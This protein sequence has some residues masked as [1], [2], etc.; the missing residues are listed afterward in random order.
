MQTIVQPVSQQPDLPQPR[1][2]LTVIPLMVVVNSLLFFLW[3]AFHLGFEL[4][5][6]SLALSEPFSLPAAFVESLCGLALAI[7]AYALFTRQRW[8]WSALFNGH[9]FAF[10]G[11]MLGM[12]ALALVPGPRSLS[13]DI[14]HNFA[15]IFLVTTLVQLQRPAVRESIETQE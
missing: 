13:N 2:A 15:L 8:A 11:V 10:A 1:M 4:P 7:G 6:G 14:Y 5:L 12:F 3:A 9:L